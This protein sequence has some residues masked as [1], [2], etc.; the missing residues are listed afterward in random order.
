LPGKIH[1][2]I[3]RESSRHGDT[4]HANFQRIH[5]GL[6]RFPSY[7]KMVNC[8]FSWIP[9]AIIIQMNTITNLEFSSLLPQRLMNAGGT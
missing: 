8:P 9:A 5:R 3:A 7:L 1:K 4:P 6:N 2:G